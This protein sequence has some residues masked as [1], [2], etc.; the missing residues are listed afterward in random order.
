MGDLRERTARVLADNSAHCAMQHEDRACPNLTILR[1]Y[2]LRYLWTHLQ[3]A[4]VRSNRHAITWYLLPV[5]RRHSHGYEGYTAVRSA[6]TC[7]RR[8]TF[9]QHHRE[10]RTGLS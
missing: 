10:Q 4:R 5:Q 7:R 8:S 2:R 9:V 6:A 1:S 3:R